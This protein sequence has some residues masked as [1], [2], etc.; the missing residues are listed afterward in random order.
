MLWLS[1]LLSGEAKRLFDALPE[2]YKLDYDFTIHNLQKKLYISRFMGRK[3]KDY[4]TWE[5]LRIEL[6]SLAKDCNPGKSNSDLDKIVLKQLCSIIK[7][8]NII[9]SEE[10]A[11]LDDTILTVSAYEAVP[12]PYTE[13]GNWEKWIQTFEKSL[14]TKK[15]T[16]NDTKLRYLQ[17]RLT[18]KASYFFLLIVK[19]QKDFEKVKE[20]LG[21][22]IYRNKF[23]KQQRQLGETWRKFTAELRNLGHKVYPPDQLDKCV[24]DKVLSDPS[25]CEMKY[26]GDV[27]EWDAWI[28]KFDQIVHSCSLDD[29]AM[30]K[31]FDASLVE[32]ARTRFYCKIPKECKATYLDAKRAMDKEIYTTLFNSVERADKESVHSFVLR[33]EKYAGKA[34]PGGAEKMTV[35]KIKEFIISD[36]INDIS[37]STLSEAVLTF[38]A[39]E[40]MKYSQYHDGDDWEWWLS[41]FEKVASRYKLKE[42]EKLQWLKACLT[43]SALETFNLYFSPSQSTYESTKNGIGIAL[44]AHKK[45]SLKKCTKCSCKPNEPMCHTEMVPLS[46]ATSGIMSVVYKVEESLF[47]SDKVCKKCGG[48]IGTKGCTP[49]ESGVRH[50]C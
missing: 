15:I 17:L 34:F 36:G 27:C 31:W 26:S 46:I 9:L 28:A 45:L 43:K 24:L 18:G 1:C 32:P 35:K 4:E 25:A 33:L 50:N 49:I 40:E 41:Q 7:N 11:S 48:A 47:Y 13:D 2:E 12:T 10:P 3:K 37:F 42:A 29:D 8:Q 23:E 5:T 38:T 44:K 21:V 22:E 19:T 6:C 30:L 39:L 16:D 20:L 14:R